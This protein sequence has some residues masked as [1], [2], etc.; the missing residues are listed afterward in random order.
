[1]EG[2]QG[3]EGAGPSALTKSALPVCPCRVDPLT[4][5][6]PLYPLLLSLCVAFCTPDTKGWRAVL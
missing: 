2:N 5:M 1:M 3:L 6:L 4:Q